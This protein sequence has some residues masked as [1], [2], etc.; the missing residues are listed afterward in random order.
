MFHQ[1]RPPLKSSR[2]EVLSWY[3]EAEGEELHMRASQRT[4]RITRVA[5]VGTVGLL[6]SLLLVGLGGA[7]MAGAQ[8]SPKSE[9]LYVGTFDGIATPP[10]QTFSTI[11]DAVNAAKRGDWIL[12]A[13]G[14]YHESD[15]SRIT[16]ANRATTDGWYGG[17]VIDTS[18]LHLLGM[19]RNTVVVDGT[20]PGSPGECNSA[21]ADQNF[22]HGLGRN[23]IVVWKAE[24]VSIDN[25][26]VCNFQ[27]G[28]GDAGNEIWWN[29]GDESGKVGLTGYEGSYLTATS[30]Y[31]E[32]SDP[33]DLSVCDTCA[34]YGI[35]SSNSS[36]GSWDQIFANNFADSGGYIGACHQVCNATVDQATFEDSALGYSGTNSGGLVH[37]EDS[38]FENNKEGLDTNTALSG[39][40]PPPQNGECP[41][42]K[43]VAGE[44]VRIPGTKI[45]SCWVFGPNNLVEHDNNANVPVEGTA[46][47]GP[48]GTGETVSGGRNDTVED[49]EFL[50][51]GAWGMLFVPYPDSDTSVVENGV[52][53]QCSK[54][55]GVQA[56][57]LHISGVGCLFDPEGDFST[58]NKFSGVG[59]DGN[60]TD[61]DLGNLLIYGNEDE[62]CASR[63]TEWNS[64]FTTETGPATTTESISTT[65]GAKT[66][67]T[68][69]LGSNTDVAFLLQ[70]EC[71]AGLLSGSDCSSAKYPQAT[72]VTMQPLPGASGLE[73]PDT[74]DLPT[75]PNPCKGAPA[76]A[77]CPGGL[78]ATTAHRH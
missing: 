20:L 32:N 55:G 16:N 71:D 74:A 12:V 7:G 61:A 57:S 15:D 58:D 44:S 66:P 73:S 17:V 63:N 22:L 1:F 75:M 31:F 35:F 37:I 56:T 29:G 40:P 30:T 14:D 67:K 59:T 25:L 33:S 34:L 27:A 45:N 9:V 36:G 4:L 24:D 78:L 51:N 19:N 46:G 48:T 26:T 69:V 49:N 77:W 23:G 50:D 76:N 52:T 6:L 65:C 8:G 3:E 21:P 13:P 28:K 11:Q 62:N 47:L 43:P 64:T 5:V 53:Y 68:T 39:D 54:E 18:D 42:N 72:G 60:A 70:A 2:P 41:G 38:T 10:A